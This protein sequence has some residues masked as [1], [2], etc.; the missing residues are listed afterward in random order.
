MPDS[1]CIIPRYLPI[2]YILNYNNFRNIFYF[3]TSSSFFTSEL[4]DTFGRVK[5]SL[6]YMLILKWW[7]A[8]LQYY[9][10]EAG[11]S[12]RREGLGSAEATEMVLNNL[13]YITAKVSYFIFFINYSNWQLAINIYKR[14]IW[15]K[16][17]THFWP[18]LI[19]NIYT[20]SLL[21]YGT[22]NIN[23][24][25]AFGSWS[26]RAKFINNSPVDIRDFHLSR[27]WWTDR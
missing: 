4:S 7:F 10:S 17:S 3:T 26:S 27:C 1:N 8:C 14:L 21:I 13:F 5:R 24:K 9:A 16:I 2:Y 19:L 12:G 15:R 23:V 25:G 6:M 18:V 22:L 20:Y 11:R